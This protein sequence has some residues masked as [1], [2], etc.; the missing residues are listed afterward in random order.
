VD[1]VRLSHPPFSPFPELAGRKYCA[2]DWAM[3]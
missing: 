2:K 3:Y 1:E